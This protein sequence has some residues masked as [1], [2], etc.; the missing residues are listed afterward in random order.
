MCP[1][2]IITIL[3]RDKGFNA[4]YCIFHNG[5]NLT[6]SIGNV[7]E[8]N[9]YV[10]L[11][12]TSYHDYVSI[13]KRNTWVNS[14]AVLDG[15]SSDRQDSRKEYR[16]L[17]L[18]VS[19]RENNFLDELKY[20]MIL[21]SDKFVEWVQRKF[22][23]RNEKADADLPQKRRISDEGVVKRVL[24]EIIHNYQNRRRILD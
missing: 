5:A 22:V 24:E 15:I 18:K 20:G 21:G 8:I 11:R 1:S 17:I 3:A 16:K 7:N 13:R 19:G 6:S 12:G 2:Q 23:D 9:T 14:E 10:F 4:I